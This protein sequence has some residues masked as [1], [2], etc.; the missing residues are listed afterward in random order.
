MVVGWDSL[1][2]HY[3]ILFRHP[4]TRSHSLCTCQVWRNTHRNCLRLIRN[5]L[6]SHLQA[7]CGFQRLTTP[8]TVFAVPSKR[9]QTWKNITKHGSNASCV[10]ILGHYVIKVL[11]EIEMS[12]HSLWEPVTHI[13]AEGSAPLIVLYSFPWLRSVT[14]PAWNF[15]VRQVFMKLLFRWR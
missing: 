13:I 1:G 12:S 2:A 3:F 8:L 14:L 4:S 15:T 9:N 5:P 6:L 10:K 7:L 11:C